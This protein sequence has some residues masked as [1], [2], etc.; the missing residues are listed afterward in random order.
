[1]TLKKKI[2]GNDEVS[3]VK[4][5][6][7]SSFK[8]PRDS[9]YPEDPRRTNERKGSGVQKASE[10]SPVHSTVPVVQPY[11]SASNVGTPE[12]PFPQGQFPPLPIGSLKKEDVERHAGQYWISSEDEIPELDV[13]SALMSDRAENSIL[14]NAVGKLVDFIQSKDKSEREKTLERLKEDKLLK[15]DV[16]LMN[17]DISKDETKAI[18]LVNYVLDSEQRIATISDFGREYWK[19]V[20]ASV[21]EA[22][23][24]YLASSL[25]DKPGVKPVPVDDPKFQRISNLVGPIVRTSLPGDLTKQILA[26]KLT[27]TEDAIFMLYKRC[28]PG[29][30]SEKQVLLK[31]LQDPIPQDVKGIK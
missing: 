9:V 24:T 15:S 27:S 30:N 2:K 8:S 3:S 25:S 12:G 22:Y 31:Y 28:S 20:M 26:Q 5:E 29:G 10:L 17:I 21:E 16:K 6:K 11:E 13:K 19:T 4:A 23:Q 18:N 1:M 7:T 14:G